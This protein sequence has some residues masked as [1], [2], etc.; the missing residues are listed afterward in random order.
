MSSL[1]KNIIFLLT[2]LIGI[3]AIAA[4]Y[5]FYT[6]QKEFTY[7][8]EQFSIALNNI[9]LDEAKLE[10]AVIENFIYSYNNNDEITHHLQNLQNDF[11]KLIAS[12]I[13][14]KKQYAP[15]QEDIGKLKNSIDKLFI[16]VNRFLMFNASVKNSFL[17]LANYDQ[18]FAHTNNKKLFLKT[19]KIVEALLFARRLNDLHFLQKVSLLD[20]T[21][22]LQPQV[23]RYIKTFNKHIRFLQKTLPLLMH[24]NDTIKNNKIK[25]E[26]QTIR[27]RFEKIALHDTTL[28][29]TFLYTLFA[30]FLITYGY[31]LVMIFRYDKEHAKLL[32][33]TASLKHSFYHDRLTNLKNRFALTEDLQTIQ[34]PSIV[35]INIDR[36]K[37]INDAY[38][39]KTG[40]KLLIE[41]AKML[42]NYF[43]AREHFVDLYRIGGDEFCLLFNNIKDEHLFKIVH[44]F[45][46]QLK[47]YEFVIDS[48]N[49]SISFSAAINSQKPLLE[50][51]DLILK[52]TKRLKTKKIAIF[53][54]NL[55][56]QSK[57]H[58]NL[59]MVKKIQEAIK[60]DGITLYFQP[61]VNIQTNQIEKFEALVR[62]QDGVDTIP[63][64]QFLEISKKAGLYHD[65]TRIVVQ[66]TLLIA[67]EYPLQRFSINLSMEDIQNNE[68]IDEIFILMQQ[69]ISVANRIDFELLE[70]EDL[71]NIEV[72]KQ[73]IDR[74]HSFG[75]LV[76]ID[77]FGSG[78]SNFS[79]F[80]DLEIDLVKIDGSIINEIVSNKRKLHMLKSITQFAKAMHMDVV[81][82]FVDSQAII[83]L[84]HEL[85]IQYAQGYYFS[86]PTPKPI[87]T[88]SH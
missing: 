82:E 52:E 26:T 86:K 4:F 35:L 72:V 2:T 87:A 42:Q 15:L 20:E 31:L 17:F 85:G 23:K 41:F 84:L 61:I 24:L 10:F 69:N 64:F 36:F 53:D 75:S 16:D 70:S 54:P 68:L 80:A 11:S 6:K 49:I 59:L 7:Q 39:T 29:N 47:E 18:K 45:Y 30:I 46:N 44:N 19:G 76:L 25:Y 58:N 74:V 21:D 65:I 40:D 9:E 13:L 3:V 66:K 34:K 51:A 60:N 14:L 37:D 83:E 57:A 62:I 78:Y 81:A 1:K 5:F 27:K 43:Q 32:Q 22:S 79:Y 63:P 77:D 71:D 12:D 73:F 48:N 28:L 8:K 33:T 38:E 50:N 88:L 56:L 55:G 67:K